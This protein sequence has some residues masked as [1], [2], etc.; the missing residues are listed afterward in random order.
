MRKIFKETEVT[1][2]HLDSSFARHDVYKNKNVIQ[3]EFLGNEHAVAE[4][5]PFLTNLILTNLT[6]IDY[7]NYEEKLADKDQMI[8]DLKSQIRWYRE[9]PKGK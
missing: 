9:L 6:P 1:I 7:E 5:A 4:M 2:F 8:E 3:V